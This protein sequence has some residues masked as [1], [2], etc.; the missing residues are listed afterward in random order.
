MV[1]HVSGSVAGALSE[2]SPGEH[3][4]DGVSYSTH[5]ASAGYGIHES[6]PGNVLALV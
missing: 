4:G 3:F 6:N 2:T 1:T 5:I